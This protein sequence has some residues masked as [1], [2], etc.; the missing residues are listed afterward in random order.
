MSL[1][2]PLDSSAD[3]ESWL[4]STRSLKT[5]GEPVSLF[6]SFPIHLKKGTLK[7]RRRVFFHALLGKLDVTVRVGTSTGAP[8]A[9]GDTTC[10]THTPA[11]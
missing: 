3:A 5:A 6:P 2:R 4:K 10:D 9:L 7:N 11:T 1:L 8:P